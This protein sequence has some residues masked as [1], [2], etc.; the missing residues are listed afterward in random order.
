MS[1]LASVLLPRLL[2]NWF[3]VM[4]TAVALYR[5]LVRTVQTPPSMSER[6]RYTPLF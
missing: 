3:L 2:L 1:R 6:L 5:L 4:Q